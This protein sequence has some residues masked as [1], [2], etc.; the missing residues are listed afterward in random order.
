MKKYTSSQQVIDFLNDG[1]FP[2]IVILT[3]P[4]GSGK[5]YLTKNQLIPELKKENNNDVHY[6][7]VYGLTSLDDFR[8]KI[9]SLNYTHNSHSSGWVSSVKNLVGGTT[10]ALGDGGTINGVISALAKP[11]KHKLLSKIKNVNI[12]IDDLERASSQKLISEVLGE[13]LNLVENNINVWVVV[14]ANIDQVGSFQLLEKTFLNRVSINPAPDD[15][16]IFIDKKYP[17]LLCD[18]LKKDLLI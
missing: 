15:I 12:V 1:S 18:V 17:N 9:L 10:R 6:I 2:T 16:M 13:I 5:T 7:S 11:I 4:W 14:V 3:G 8:D